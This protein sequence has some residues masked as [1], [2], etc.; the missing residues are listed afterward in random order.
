[1]ASCSAS[2][3]RLSA[4]PSRM[5]SIRVRR[6]RSVSGNTKSVRGELMT[7][8]RIALV[9]G[10]NAGIGRHVAE[11]L[12]ERGVK[13][14]LGARD[15]QRG[16]TVVDELSARSLP[17]EL[18]LLDVTDA[19]SI[20]A[21]ADLV[22]ERH[23][24]LDILVNNAGITSGL[25]ATSHTQVEDLRRT[26]ET[27]VFGV[28]AVTNAFLPMLRR[29][30]AARIVN[31]SSGLG[32]AALMN[33]STAFGGLNNAAYQSSKAALN[34]LT[35]LFANELRDE[36]ILVNAVSPGYRATGLNGGL[37]TPGAGDAAG[38]ADVVTQAALLPDDGPTGTFMADTGE[39]YP[40]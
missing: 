26:Y 18:L 19:A 2:L 8:Q 12:A 4:A 25:D 21:A 35:F 1:M 38:G 5:S 23:G 36:G 27:N 9:T 30:T 24:R 14:L 10:A 32:S 16:R 33:R 20:A 11:Q 15:A 29:S 34:M 17:V 37:P 31:V 22:R 28:V 13:V 6:G 39:N 7:E 40:W 3:A